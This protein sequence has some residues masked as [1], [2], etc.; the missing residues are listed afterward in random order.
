MRGRID[1]ASASANHGH[2]DISQLVS[3]LAGCFLSVGRRHPR[4]DQGDGV[5]VLLRKG[6]L[7]V[8]NDRW[9]INFSQERRVFGVELS[10]DFAAEFTDALEFT[11]EINLT[12][13]MGNG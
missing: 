9:I 13:P 10:H 12:F 5:L 8:E 4:A 3:E 6:T 11:F 2:A 7:H 1:A